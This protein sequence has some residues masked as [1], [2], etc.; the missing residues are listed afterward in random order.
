M[1]HKLQ[2]NIIYYFLFL[3]GICI[4]GFYKTYLIHFP[5]FEGFASVHHFHGLLALSWILLLISQAYLVRSKKYTIHKAM[6]KLSYIIMPL[7]IISLFLVAKEGYYRNLSKLGEQEAL[8]ALTNGIPD[9]FFFSIIYTLAIVKKKDAAS[10]MRYMTSTGIMMLGPGLGRFMIVFCGLPFPVVIITMIL[11]T[12]GIAMVWLF[13]D[14]KNKKP[15]T[16]MSVLSLISIFGTLIQMNGQGEI[17]K[18][19]A[20]WFVKSFF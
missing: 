13:M 17:W 12:L 19:F 7:F 16:P 6:G 18:S 8:T 20:A 11:L 5:N 4:L 3:L 14:Y 1:E 15:I 2:N 9:I 10:H